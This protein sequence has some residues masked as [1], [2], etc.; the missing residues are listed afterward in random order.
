MKERGGVG[1]DERGGQKGGVGVAIE[2][3]DCNNAAPGLAEG[4]VIDEV[5]GV[6]SASIGRSEGVSYNDVHSEKRASISTSY[7]SISRE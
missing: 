7:P 4:K 6:Y 2:T 5:D 3:V 1:G